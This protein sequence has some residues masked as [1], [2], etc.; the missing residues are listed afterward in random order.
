MGEREACYRHGDRLTGL[1]CTRCGNPTCPDCMIP[2][3]VGHHCPACV[4]GARM[5]A[6]CVKKCPTGR[7]R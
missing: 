3:P 6:L 7:R 5:D 4:A 2:A 1:H